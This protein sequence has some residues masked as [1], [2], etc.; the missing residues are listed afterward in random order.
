MFS[1][2]PTK[3]FVSLASVTSTS[4]ATRRFPRRSIPVA[5]GFSGCEAAPRA[6]AGRSVSASGGA[7]PSVEVR[8]ASMGD[9]TV[10]IEDAAWRVGA[11]YG[12]ATGR[13]GIATSRARSSTTSASPAYASRM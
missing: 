7:D 9:A 8:T 11:G 4:K 13:C 5:T 2:N 6:L 3:K 10:V 1:A 12:G